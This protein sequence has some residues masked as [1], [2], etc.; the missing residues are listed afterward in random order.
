[1]YEINT[2]KN[3]DENEGP[4]LK[5]K[6][7][8]ILILLILFITLASGATPP[9]PQKTIADPSTT[10]DQKD[11]KRILSEREIYLSIIVILFGL[12]LVILTVYIAHGNNRG[13]DQE[14]TRIFSFSVVI[15]AG[16]FLM[17]AGYDSEQ[18]APMFGLLGTIVGYLLGKSSPK[19][20]SI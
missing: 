11:I 4:M 20:E 12:I 15:T 10:N 1:M 5:I 7:L 14:A 3:N 9:A 6:I 16:L 19:Q 18:V 2:L 8:S 13:W 17:T